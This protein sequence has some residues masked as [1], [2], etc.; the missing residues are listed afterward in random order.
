[1][2]TVLNLP[3]H[4]PQP[5]RISYGFSLMI[6][7]QFFR[8]FQ[9]FAS[10]VKHFYEINTWKN[11]LIIFFLWKWFKTWNDFGKE[12]ASEG[13]E[14]AYI[15]RT[16]FFMYSYSTAYLKS[17]VWLLLVAVTLP[18]T[19]ASCERSFSK[20]KLVKTIPRNSMTSERL[21]NIDLLSVERYELKNRFRWFCWWIWQSA[22]QSKD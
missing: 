3:A 13:V 19:S 9:L 12:F 18:A 11:S 2:S 16:F 15:A 8:V 6:Q 1:M 17:C 4:I 20:M 21:G 22:W 14:A 10:E 5:H 7:K